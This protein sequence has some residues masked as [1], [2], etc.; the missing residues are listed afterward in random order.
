ML[1]RFDWVTL[2]R[3]PRTDRGERPCWSRFCNAWLAGWAATSGRAGAAPSART[4]WSSAG[5]AAS[6]PSDTGNWP[7]GSTP[8]GQRLRARGWCVKTMSVRISTAD[9]EQ[10]DA[11][12]RGKQHGF[13]IRTPQ[14]PKVRSHRPRAGERTGAI[15]LSRNDTYKLT[16]RINK[17]AG[18]I[19]GA[20][21]A[22]AG[23]DTA[24]ASRKLGDSARAL[25]ELA[26]TIKEL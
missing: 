10:S 18:S 13:I 23:D 21:R 12:S 8:T 24:R 19:D 3:Y 16:A 17:A 14:A 1:A 2:T 25:R 9:T 7:A 15:P 6:K 11:P 5:D 22:H 26:S 4:R 20:A